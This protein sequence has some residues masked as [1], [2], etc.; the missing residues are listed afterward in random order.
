MEEILRNGG[1]HARSIRNRVTEG[2]VILTTWTQNPHSPQQDGLTSVEQ[3]ESMPPDHTYGTRSAMPH[4]L[5]RPG[6]WARLV[7]SGLFE[8]ALAGLLGAF[9]A[10]IHLASGPTWQP[11]VLDLAA[12]VAAAT[13]GKLPRI[14][15][16][17][18]AAVLIVYLLVPSQWAT[19]GEYA[20][21]IPVLGTGLR[22]ARTMRRVWTCIYFPIVCAV[23]WFDAPDATRAVLAWVFWAVAFGVL[24]VIGNVYAATV[25]AQQ[26][27][28]AAELLKQRQALARGLHD[29]VARSLTRV[30]MAAERAR[31]RGTASDADMAVISDAAASAAE[32]LRWVMVLLREPVSEPKE[33]APTSIRQALAEAEASLTRHGF[34]VTLTI[35][36]DAN[37]LATTQEEALTA[38]IAEA[39]M[40]VVKHGEPD[41]A[42]GIFVGIGHAEA[43]LVF[44]N[45][46]RRN[47]EQRDGT[48]SMGL[49][50]V[51]QSLAPVEGQLLIE[52][53]PEEWITR[54]RV[55]ISHGLSSPKASRD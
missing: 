54:V 6:P 10:T 9:A 42:C 12:C 11:L 28:R 51:R 45:R 48:R 36:G 14:G 18:L 31:L 3:H 5:N 2:V 41:S 39:A 26:E 25:A 47:A 52:N 44:A 34:L 38:A 27:A 13:S 32:E 22:G 8:A 7:D 16:A 15:G 17:A 23:T 21:F 46:R 43:E 35:E 55:P 50:N 53:N 20:A 4:H 24:W 40:N 1:M 49:D 33:L 29:T 19:L 37:G 30:A